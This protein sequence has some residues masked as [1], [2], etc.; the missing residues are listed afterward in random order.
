MN[1]CGA[2][3]LLSVEN[4]RA[5]ALLVDCATLSQASLDESVGRLP[6]SRC[7]RRSLS[8][9]LVDL[10][11]RQ[12]L[13]L[14]DKEV[15]VHES[16]GAET[17]PDEEDRGAEVALVLVDHVRGDD[18]DD[19][20]PEPVGG[21][22]ESD[23]TGA[24]GQGEDL[25]DE[26]PRAGTPGGGEEEDEDGDEGDLGVDGGDVVGAGGAVGEGGGVVE[27]SRG[28]WGSLKLLATAKGGYAVLNY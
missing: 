24:D 8:H 17:T 2:L 9:H 10:F 19:G 1:R 16:D 21:G 3:V 14:R 27:A 18:G 28:S 6:L 22:G 15:S 12:T 13:G 23:T 20:V 7:A 11:E 5:V 25:A 26:D 4:N